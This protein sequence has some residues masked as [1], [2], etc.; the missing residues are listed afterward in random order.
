M[1]LF[2]TIWLFFMSLSLSLSLSLS[3]KIKILFCS[4][5]AFEHVQ[6]YTQFFSLLFV[7][8]EDES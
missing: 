3:W 8:F 2:G 1:F 6:L 7:Y 5:H 4:L